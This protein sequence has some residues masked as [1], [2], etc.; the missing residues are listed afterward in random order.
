MPCAIALHRV[1][2]SQAGQTEIHEY[3]LGGPGAPIWTLP[4]GFT[5]NCIGH[6]LGTLYVAGTYF[7]G[8]AG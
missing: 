3:Q 8:S 6:S 2:V 5:G 7:D 1:M 4:E